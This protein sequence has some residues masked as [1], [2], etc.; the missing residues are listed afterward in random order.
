MATAQ[1]SKTSADPRSQILNTA[2]WEFA[3]YGYAGASLDEVARKVGKTRQA[4]LYHF[5]SKAALYEAV[6][7]RLFEP[8]L[9]QLE[10]VFNRKY[11]SEFERLTALLASWIHW[12]CD[13]PNYASIFLHN[14]AG[15]L[16][17][18]QPFWRKAA[19]LQVFYKDT[20]RQG[21]QTGEFTDCSMSE[22]VALTGGYTACYLQMATPTR[23]DWTRL[24]ANLINLCRALL[25][26]RG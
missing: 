8:Q 1:R 10:E 16:D 9:A 7:Q 13:N 11:N 15:G 24:H 6:L 22:L 3:R 20:L 21:R 17:E 14:L 25:I 26:P 19:D 5:K 4:V 18:E 12:V 23:V 2:E